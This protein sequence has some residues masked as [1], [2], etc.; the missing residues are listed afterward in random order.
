MICNLLPWM[1]NERGLTDNKYI[2][3]HNNPFIGGVRHRHVY[4]HNGSVQHTSVQRFSQEEVL[5]LELQ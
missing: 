4:C 5:R 2:H 1:Q 3:N